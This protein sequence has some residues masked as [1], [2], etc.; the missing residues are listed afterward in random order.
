MPDRPLSPAVYSLN[1]LHIN[2]T[3]SRVDPEEWTVKID[4]RETKI[5]LGGMARLINAI[6]E[7]KKTKNHVLFLHAGDTY[8]GT[9][10]FVHY[11]GAAERDFLNLMAPDAMV[12]GNHEFDQGAAFLGRFINELHFPV[13]SANTQANPESGLH[14]KIPPYL[15]K[16]IKSRKIGII[17]LTTVETRHA[18]SPGSQV[19]F[20]D[21]LVAADRYCRDLE[22]QGINKIIIL[23]HLGF[24]MDRKL[25]QAVSG[26]DIIVGGHSHTPMGNFKRFGI[27]AVNAYPWIEKSPDGSMVLIVQAWE[28]AKVLGSINLQ[29][30]ANGHITGYD[31]RPK[32][33]VGP[34]FR[35]RWQDTNGDGTVDASDQ[36]TE[37][38]P[39]NAPERYQS[40]VRFI[41]EDETVGYYKE[42]EAAKVLRDQ[43]ARG[44]EDLR[45]TVAA[46]AL[47]NL[48]GK[49]SNCGAGP[50]VADSML[51]KTKAFGAVMA[52]ENVRALR[53]E[54]TKGDITIGRIYELLPFRNKLVL[55]D[56]GA[57]EIKQVLEEAIDHSWR[58]IG[59]GEGKYVY[60]SGVKCRVDLSKTMGERVSGIAVKID[61]AYGPLKESHKYRV[62]TNSFLAAGGDNYRTFKAATSRQ[63]TDFID[64]EVFLEY[65]KKLRT[66]VNPS[67]ARLIMEDGG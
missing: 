26:I 64:A 6:E 58:K 30:D 25:A 48:S 9:L 17:G 52:V 16:E 11:Q 42:H 29:F 19:S 27:D 54:I 18:S 46:V 39:Q 21:P 38:T 55:I 7:E 28:W 8:P 23:S 41:K 47:E 51:W 37:I 40:I 53:S 59:Y 12:A 2:D 15:T 50:L 14:G 22:K 61:G 20:Q 31:G 13:L 32:L 49:G 57:A 36:Y 65:V 66:L 63:E 60:I 34:P 1:I 4:G 10:Y 3:H 67:E 33:I 24:A 43:Y 44:L 56:L 5:Q 35:Q 62:V 45:K